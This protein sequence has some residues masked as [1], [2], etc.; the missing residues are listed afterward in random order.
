MK[1][2]FSALILFVSLMTIG[3]SDSPPGVRVRNDYTK[4]ANVQVKNLAGQTYNINGVEG[5]R[6]T[7]LIDIAEGDYTAKAEIPSDTT[8][9]EATFTAKTNMQYLVIVTNTT[10]P[11]MRIESEDR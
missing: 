2:L 9:P 7:T 4:K 10:P 6:E 1:H 11:V 3:C 5:G 8:T